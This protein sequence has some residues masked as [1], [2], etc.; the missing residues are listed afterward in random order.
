[1]NNQWVS[2]Q[3]NV[4]YD[5]RFHTDPITEKWWTLDMMLDIDT[6]TEVYRDG[7]DIYI[8]I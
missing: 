1:M 7:G 3:Y 5:K 4:V 6:W 2:I 8:Y